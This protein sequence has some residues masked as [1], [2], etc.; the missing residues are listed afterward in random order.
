VTPTIYKKICLLG[1]FAVG[2]TSLVRRYVDNQFSDEYLTTVGVKISRKLVELSKDSGER[3]A[4]QLIV[5]DLEGKSNFAET[6]NAYLQGASGAII[7]GDVTHPDSIANIAN[8]IKAFLAV[9]AR[10][11]IVA[12][13]NKA[14]LVPERELPSFPRFQGH[15]RVICAKNT[16]AKTGEGV[17]DLFVL[18]AERMIR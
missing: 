12:A 8:H 13:G 5:W 14:D 9:N 15:E 3:V 17:E 1:D 11:C 16:S 18:L 6:S 10:S 7:V 2:K 4:L